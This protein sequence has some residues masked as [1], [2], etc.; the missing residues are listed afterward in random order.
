MNASA[1]DLGR[2]SEAAACGAETQARTRERTKAG[3]DG[4]MEAVCER[5]NLWLAYQRVVENKGAGGVN[6]ITVTEFKAHL[7]Q[8]WPAIKGKLL[9]PPAD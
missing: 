8:H 2:N 4:L 9:P 5:G 6:G 1:A 3:L 7:K